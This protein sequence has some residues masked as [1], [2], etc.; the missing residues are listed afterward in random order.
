MTITER[1]RAKVEE[2][3][4]P[5]LEPGEQIDAPLSFAQTGPSPWFAA[6]TYFIFFMIST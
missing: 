6:L 5:Q 4:G 3:V 2:F 1:R